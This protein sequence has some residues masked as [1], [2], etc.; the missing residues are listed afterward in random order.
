MSRDLES[1]FYE[2]AV[3]ENENQRRRLSM[4]AE[5]DATASVSFTYKTKR[6]NEKNFIGFY[7]YEIISLCKLRSWRF[8]LCQRIATL[9]KQNNAKYRK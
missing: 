5:A 7:I 3:R 9:E 2:L 8:G 6:K 1:I 4:N